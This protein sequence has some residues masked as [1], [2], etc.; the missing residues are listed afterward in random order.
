MTERPKVVT[1][2]ALLILYSE[3]QDGMEVPSI[4]G[5][6]VSRLYQT[7]PTN[8]VKPER[9]HRMGNN[10][11]SL[12]VFA[13]FPHFEGYVGALTS[14]LTPEQYHE[15]LRHERPNVSVS[16]HSNLEDQHQM[17]MGDNEGFR[18]FAYMTMAQAYGSGFELGEN[19]LETWEG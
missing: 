5:S 18:E 7:R 6:E 19:R 13:G 1:L 10:E 16:H 11:E 17:E 12:V 2:S 14:G 9:V 8:L 3:D 4:S 15:V